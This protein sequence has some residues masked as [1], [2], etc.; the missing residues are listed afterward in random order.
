M[1][2]TSKLLIALV[3]GASMQSMASD[4]SAR[5]ALCDSQWK[6]LAASAGKD[7]E[8]LEVAWK[9]KDKECSGTG[10]YEYRLATLAEINGRRDDAISILDGAIKKKLP[11]SDDM[12]AIRLGMLFSKA[13]FATPKDSAQ[14]KKAHAELEAL[15]VSKPDLVPAMLQLSMQR[16]E[17]EDFVGAEQMSRKALQHEPDAWQP[18]RS[19]FLALV[20]LDKYSEAR[21]L[22]RPTLQLHERFFSDS[23][24]M[25]GAAFCY[26]KLGELKT[27]EQALRALL[28]KV[29]DI[30]ND[31]GY[32][33]L[34]RLV[35]DAQSRAQSKP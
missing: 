4:E 18:R 33:Q 7:L 23:E 8:S 26:Y 11:L 34:T 20:A 3:L 28:T 10:I 35:L 31:R 24:F 2:S 1:L 19:L 21:Q 14:A 27:A 17:L 25:L 16:L 6:A 29:P 5:Y 32:Q 9:G 30:Q 15:L 13:Q 12:R 22:I